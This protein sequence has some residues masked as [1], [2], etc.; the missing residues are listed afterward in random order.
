V[1]RATPGDQPESL[2]S[3]TAWSY[4]VT[5]E[6]ATVADSDPSASKSADSK[7]QVPEGACVIEGAG[8]FATIAALQSTILQLFTHSGAARFQKIRITDW[9]DYSV[10]G[11]MMDLGRRFV[12]K[13]T[14]LSQV[15]D[16][17]AL[18][19]MNVLHLHLNDFCRFSIDLPGFPMLN[20]SLAGGV[21]DGQYSV[22]DIREIVAYAR[23]R[24]VM[25]L[26]EVDLPGHANGLLPLEEQ[27]LQFC[28]PAVGSLPRPEQAAK[29]YDDPAGESRAVLRRLLAEVSHAFGE[30]IR[31][32]H[33]GGDEA[34]PMG[35][36]TTDSIVSLEGFLVK[37]VVMGDLGLEAV[38]WEELRF[39]DTDARGFSAA[40][41]S[42][43]TIIMAWRSASAR[44]V[45]RRHHR[46]IVAYVDHHYLDFSYEVHPPHY[47]WYDISAPKGGAD[48]H[49]CAKLTWRKVPKAYLGELPFRQGQGVGFFKLND[50]QE[51]CVRIGP[52]CKGVTCAGDADLDAASV[53]CQPRRGAPFLAPSKYEDSWV[54]ECT[55][56]EQSLGQKL[57]GAISPMWTDKY[58]Y[59]Y[60]C[61]AAA[62]VWASEE[63]LPS[64]AI[65]FKRQ[66]DQSFALSLAGKIWPRAAATA[67]ST[68]HY[69]ES[70]SSK[71]A[72]DLIRFSA[73]FLKQH[74]VASCPPGCT[75]SEVLSCGQPYAVIWRDSSSQVNM[76]PNTEQM[77]SDEFLER[78]FVKGADGFVDFGPPPKGYRSFQGSLRE[79]MALCF[80]L[81]SSCHGLACTTAR[82]EDLASRNG[83]SVCRVHR[84]PPARAT[85]ISETWSKDVQNP[86]CIP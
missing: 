30:S 60:Q 17:M 80:W 71:Q 66:L 39:K 43:S 57:L 86:H 24:A 79:T 50:A 54:K 10:R 85:E 82:S 8:T 14:L 52:G 36:C 11:L 55:D 63:T 78:C 5:C 40:G 19:R 41:S 56:Q 33:V 32:L 22:Q 61:G 37:D 73:G 45:A 18:T 68:W 20:R 58:C 53:T 51:E 29:V 28:K 67:A 70:L 3:K 42:N 25:L 62:S 59:T 6:V 26:P 21:L 49:E 16:G 81:G 15:I 4:N 48:T 77:Q 31:W 2:D 1:V 84:R 83:E 64:A 47:F 34:D 76:L 72:S 65:M 69:N 75:C 74:G 9:P 7:K 35:K 27:G 44:K 38:A 12:P 23:D 13:E 46:A